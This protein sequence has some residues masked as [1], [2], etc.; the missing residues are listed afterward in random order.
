MAGSDFEFRIAN[1]EFSPSSCSLQAASFF[2]VLVR[3]RLLAASCQLLGRLEAA[4]CSL[5][6]AS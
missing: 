5:Q 3:C 1:F 4:G 2:M 6:A